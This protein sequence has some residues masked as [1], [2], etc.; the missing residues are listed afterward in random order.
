MAHSR[1]LILIERKKDEIRE[2]RRRDHLLD[3]KHPQILHRM[4]R[5]KSLSPLGEFYIFMVEAQGSA[6]TT[7]MVTP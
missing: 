6:R 4:H 7:W 1:Y 5:D 2:E 3:Y